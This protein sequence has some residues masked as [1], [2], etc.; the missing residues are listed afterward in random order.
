MKKVISV[1]IIMMFILFICKEI[2]ATSSNYATS[3]K[4]KINEEN[5]YIYTVDASTPVLGFFSN[6]TVNSSLTYHVYD[7]DGN[8]KADD[9]KLVTGD[10]L[11]F[12]NREQY[13][14]S[15]TRFKLRWKSNH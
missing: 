5:R 14:I 12:K 2:Y 4:Y 3:S 15:V 7:K 6:L 10:L 1:I 11:M 8:K 9:Q 13:V